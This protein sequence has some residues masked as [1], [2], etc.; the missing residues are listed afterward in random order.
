MFDIKKYCMFLVVSVL[1]RKKGGVS[2]MKRKFTSIILVL[3]LVF[4]AT[5]PAFAEE[6]VAQISVG[7]T[8][9]KSVVSSDSAVQAAY[10][11]YFKILDAMDK[12]DL[13]AL[14]TAYYE[15]DS[16][17][18]SFETDSQQEEWNTIIEEKIGLEVALNNMFEAAYIIFVFEL[19]DEYSANPCVETAYAFVSAYDLCA[20]LE[21]PVA[22]YDSDILTIYDQAME[23]M[24]SDSVI[25]VLDGYQMLESLIFWGSLDD[26]DE[27]NEIYAAFIDQ[28]NNLTDE[29]FEQLALLLEFESGEEV[30]SAIETTFTEIQTI[31]DLNDALSAFEKKASVETATKIVELYKLVDPDNDESALLP[32]DILYQFFPDIDEVYEEAKALLESDSSEKDTDKDAN[33]VTSDIPLTGDTLD[34]ELAL[35]TLIVSAG[36][37]ILMRKKEQNMNH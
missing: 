28:Y 6:D 5:V 26:L 27:I 3:L 22:D 11:A 17:I 21:Y 33:T 2:F 24:P 7:T 10:D 35:V 9:T 4:T 36:I 15:Y 13:E 37:I 14:E 16:A 25:V 12:K 31:N 30:K 34:M 18:E 23:D 20:A 29:E 32:Y 8:E 1:L 19:A